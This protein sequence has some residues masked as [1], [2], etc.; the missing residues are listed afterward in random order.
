M[1]TGDLRTRRTFLADLGRGSVA[2]AVLSVVGCSSTVSSAVTGSARPSTAPASRPG[3]TSLAPASPTATTDA[4]ATTPLASA[5]GASGGPGFAWTR[6]N[7]GFVSA[8]ILV[9]G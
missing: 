6:V 7:L 2:L 3:A 8:Y 1:V 5:S 9:R 4:T